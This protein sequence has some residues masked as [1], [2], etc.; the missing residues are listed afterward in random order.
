MNNA[1]TLLLASALAFLVGLLVGL[2]VWA[3]ARSAHERG[4]RAFR[5]ERER[6]AGALREE[7]AGLRAARESETEKL[8]WSE[9]AER[10][11]REAFEALAGQTL[12]RNAESYTVQAK[13]GLQG[14][15]GPLQEKLV[16]LDAH[17]RELE[18]RRQGAYE[19]LTT[20]VR[21]LKETHRQLHESTTNLRAALKSPTARGRWGEMQ[22]RRVVEMA[23]M[24][25]HVDFDE[26]STEGG[27][28]RP[29][30]VARL[31]GGG[32][33]PIDAKVPLGAYLSAMETED[34]DARR[35]HLAAHA[36]ALK[37][38]VR[39][40]SQKAYWEQFAVTPGFVVMFVPNEACLGAAFQEDAA[41]FEYATEKKVLVCS[42]VN[43]YALL[44]AVAF[45]WQQQEVTDNAR[46]IA[47]EGS[48]LYGRILKFVSL[49]GDIGRHLERSVK[50]YNA[51]TGSLER[52]LAPAARRFQELG[53]GAE[54]VEEPKTLEIT[55]TPPSLFDGEG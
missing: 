37:S 20:Q 43:L 15:I 33:L 14:V 53:L 5:E 45:G 18:Q 10:R 49:Y 11:L 21:D 46:K 42:P 22:L 8:A 51:A 41:L 36:Q 40:L 39:E 1:T 25:R 12:Q 26:Q 44:K 27:D 48:D 19:S 30:L 38:R 55:P 24:E 17:V 29:D 50:A 7:L 3:R 4:D 13:Q 34:D 28:G 35:R 47:S 54:P 31:P 32:I 23:G 2:A 16:S 9:Q 52:R 6:E